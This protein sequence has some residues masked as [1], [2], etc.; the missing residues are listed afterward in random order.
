MDFM[1]VQQVWVQKP[2]KHH[3]SMCFNTWDDHRA[4]LD[5][6]QHLKLKIIAI[7]VQQ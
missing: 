5:W 2:N 6:K 7:K 3:T 1:F 4:L